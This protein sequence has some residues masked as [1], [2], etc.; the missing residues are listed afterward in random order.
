T[1]FCICVSALA[2]SFDQLIEPKAG[3]WKTWIISSGKDFRVPPPPNAGATQG[4]LAWLRAA[5]TE[6]DPEIAAS[7][8]FWD[9][10]AP[11]YR[12]LDLITNRV[13][14]GAPMTAYPHRVY[15]YV[16]LAMYDATIAAWESKYAYNRARP[17]E[18]DP[19]LRTRLRTPR[20]PS[21]P[22]E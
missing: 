7:V 4:E 10:G 8:T 1:V 9:A 20:S 12:W 22:S 14:A 16:V 3:A 18:L 21:Y 13:L 5:V 17:A 19:T 2:Q 11:S 15:T 6:T